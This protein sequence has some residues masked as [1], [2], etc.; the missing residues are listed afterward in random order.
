M[1]FL[2]SF[3]SELIEPVRIS[4][5]NKIYLWTGDSQPWPRIR[6]T[7]GIMTTPSGYRAFPLTKIESLQ[8]RPRHQDLKK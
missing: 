7:W 5:L 4:V 3:Y 2:C 8:V 1:D 6:I